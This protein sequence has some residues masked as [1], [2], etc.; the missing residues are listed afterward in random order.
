MG[1]REAGSVAGLYETPRS[2]RAFTGEMKMKDLSCSPDQ[3]QAWG[4]F[5]SLLTLGPIWRLFLFTLP[6]SPL[7]RHPEF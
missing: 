1:Y 4:C 6:W 5:Q 3:A 7:S 2:F